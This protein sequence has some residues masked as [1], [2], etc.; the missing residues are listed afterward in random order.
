MF[1]PSLVQ[2]DFIF[3]YRGSIYWLPRWSLTSHIFVRKGK[4]MVFFW[5]ARWYKVW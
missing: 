4:A 5:L 3:E 2:N 1:D